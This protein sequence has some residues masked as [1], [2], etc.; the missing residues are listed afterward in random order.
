MWFIWRE[1]SIGSHKSGS[2]LPYREL[3]T[4]SYDMADK[5]IAIKSV[6]LITTRSPQPYGE[7]V[8]HVGPDAPRCRK[9]LVALATVGSTSLLF[10]A[11]QML[12]HG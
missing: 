11:S 12:W 9:G 8:P 3:G 7:G 6:G 1:T 5:Q 2:P 10:A 4:L